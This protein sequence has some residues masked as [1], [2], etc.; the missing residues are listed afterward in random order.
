MEHPEKGN[1]VAVYKLAKKI[2]FKDKMLEKS[3]LPPTGKV[4]PKVKN[5]KNFFK[6]PLFQTS[7]FQFQ[8][9]DCVVMGWGLTTRDTE[10]GRGSTD[11]LE[12]HVGMLSDEDCK[13]PNF[14]GYDYQKLICASQEKGGS[15]NGYKLI[16]FR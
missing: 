7:P 9:D 1:D 11:L 2:N 4:E 12:F 16:L 10:H 6:T 8:G 14:R 5:I 3:C 15:C 13:K